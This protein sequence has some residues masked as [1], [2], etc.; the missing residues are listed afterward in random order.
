[1]SVVAMS[2]A[3]RGR[4]EIAADVAEVATAR[5]FVR[6]VLTGLPDRLVADAQLIT[7][8]LVTNAIEHGVG[9]PVVVAV[10]RCATCVGLTVESVGPAPDVGDVDEWEM[11]DVQQRTGRGLG[12]VRLVADTVA[13]K[14][15]SDGLVITARLLR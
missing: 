4:L 10:D 7:S 14:R 5:R 15:S 1:V 12:I 6:T 11:A 13:V 3:D 2:D 9:G 8:E